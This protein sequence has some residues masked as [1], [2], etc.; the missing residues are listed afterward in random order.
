[1][2]ILIHVGLGKTATT[3][4]QSCFAK[5]PN[6]FY[7]GTSPFHPGL[8][9]INEL[10]REL[11][12]DF[13]SITDP[14]LRARNSRFVVKKYAK[15]VAD[16]IKTQL[17]LGNKIDL[18]ILSEE[19][20]ADY[21]LYNAELLV[22]MLPSL[23]SILEDEINSTPIIQKQDQNETKKTH[24]PFHKHLLFTTREQISFLQ[25]YYAFNYFRLCRRF[26]NI[27]T[28]LTHG[29]DHNTA[30]I[31]GGLWFNEI[32]KFYGEL[33]PDWDTIFVPFEFLRESPF[34]YLSS[35]LSPLIKRNVI[36]EN[37]LEKISFQQKALNVNS[38]QNS[39]NY[40]HHFGPQ[41][42]NKHISIL[43]KKFDV[44]LRQNRIRAVLKPFANKIRSTSEYRIPEHYTKEIRKIYTS[45]NKN[46]S[47]MIGIDL[48]RLGY[49]DE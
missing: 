9:K 49:Y 24:F 40:I 4:L 48:G 1:M 5:L 29:I 3:W 17:N 26:P 25:S 36:Q 23:I 14:W 34:L 11:F 27:D 39:S 30:G 21:G 6:T 8:P 45:S 44:Y 41:F 7:I 15:M 42:L 12:I 18:I 22:A 16:Q 38:S 47:D 32:K 20:I 43:A 10:H 13:D 28:F 35:C 33:L 37:D 2:H 31:F 19:R 46:L